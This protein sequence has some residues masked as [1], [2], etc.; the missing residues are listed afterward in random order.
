MFNFAQGVLSYLGVPGA[1]GLASHSDPVQDSCRQRMS[2]AAYVGRDSTSLSSMS[3]TTIE[4]LRAR[5]ASSLTVFDDPRYAR[6]DVPDLVHRAIPRCEAP[7]TITTSLYAISCATLRWRSA[8]L[9]ARDTSWLPSV[10]VRTIPRPE[11]RERFCLKRGNSKHSRAACNTSRMLG[12]RFCCG[13]VSRS[14]IGPQ[15]EPS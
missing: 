3:P 4:D 1:S 9:K 6:L 12:S 8:S 10:P 11:V 7:R 13:H 15:L 14:P 2:V 5:V